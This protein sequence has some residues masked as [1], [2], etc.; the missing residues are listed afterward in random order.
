ME[1]R[2]GSG[3]PP[4]L[5]LWQI[6][7]SARGR[8]L[9]GSARGRRD[10]GRGPVAQDLIVLLFLFCFSWQFFFFRWFT[11]LSDFYFDFLFSKQLRI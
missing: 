11:S 10:M 4:S 6:L 3:S 2:Y 9:V 7:C 8:A 5:L 1:A